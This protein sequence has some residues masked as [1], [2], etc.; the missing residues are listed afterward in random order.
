MKSILY[1]LFIFFSLSVF[2]QNIS[3]LFTGTL[4]NDSTKKVQHYELALS[5]YRG[6]ITGYSYTTFVVNDTFYYS[7]KRVKATKEDGNLI[8]EDAKMLANN[9]PES[10]AKG[11]RQIVTVPLNN[12]DSVI[13]LKGK[14]KT[15]QTKVYYSLQGSVDMKRDN[16]SA[17]SALV[18]HLNELN[19]INGPSYA[20]AETKTKADGNRQ[21]T[22]TETGNKPDT[23]PSVHTIAG[24]IPPEK[25][26]INILQ[27]LDIASDSLVLSFYDNGVVDGDSIS[28][29][30]NGQYIINKARLTAAASKKTIYTNAVDAG[31]LQLTLIAE[32]LGSIPPNTGLLIIQDG[33]KRYEIR[34]SAD[35]QTNAAITLRKR[36]P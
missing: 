32:N 31:V 6:R 36:K 33:S 9:F 8:V 1:F 2:A 24:E 11:V 3:G 13:D 30:L 5:E 26:A 10:P 28:V 34:F 29:L 12:Q 25:R 15:T 20:A 23:Y 14:W 4:V 7:V 19:I 27:A 22:K 16:D 18:A 17:H 35:M 21:K